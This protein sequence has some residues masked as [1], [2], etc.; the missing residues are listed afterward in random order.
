M[1]GELSLPHWRRAQQ[2]LKL[3]GAVFRDTTDAYEEAGARFSADLTRRL[4]PTV[5][6]TYGVALDLTRTDE[7]V[8]DSTGLTSTVRQNLA[9]LTTLA[10][11]ALDR[12]DDVLDPHTGWRVEAR[13]SPR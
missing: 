11:Y 4:R 9:T 1:E 10:A 2:T 6:R 8:Q 12:S 7:L 13:P 3:N 5:Y